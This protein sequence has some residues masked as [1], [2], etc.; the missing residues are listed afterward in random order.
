MQRQRIQKKNKNELQMGIE[1]VTFR[2]LV[3]ALVEKVVGSI[4]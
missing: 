3:G 2:T 1:T 4:P